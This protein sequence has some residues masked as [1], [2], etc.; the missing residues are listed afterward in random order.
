MLP[1]SGKKIFS[2][3]WWALIFAAGIC[4][5]AVDFADTSDTGNSVDANADAADLD[6]V[7]DTFRHM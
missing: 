6:H 5:T 2:N 7:V 3:R 4:W 1:I